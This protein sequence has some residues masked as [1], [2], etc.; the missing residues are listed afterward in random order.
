[1]SAET[2]RALSAALTEHL[3]DEGIL[4][5][6]EFVGD[7]IASVYLP[8]LAN[9]DESAYATVM[10]G[11]SLPDHVAVGLLSVALDRV[12]GIGEFEEDD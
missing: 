1:M 11:G 3:A 8:S 4:D 12:R 7:W 2:E 5:E 6:S 10:T 9:R